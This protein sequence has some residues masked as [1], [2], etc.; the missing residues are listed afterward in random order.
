M[1]RLCGWVLLF[2]W[3]FFVTASGGA[4]TNSSPATNLISFHFV[5]SATNA[6][7]YGPAALSNVVA[8][9][10]PVLSDKDFV[11]FDVKKQEFTI[12]GAA[13]KRLADRIWEKGGREPYLLNGDVYELIPFP[14]LFVMKAEGQPI[15][16]GL[17]G[18]MVSSM[19]FSGPTIL[20]DEYAISPKQKANVDFRIWAGYPQPNGFNDSGKSDT[21][22]DSRI[23]AAVAKLFKRQ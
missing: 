23:S 11:S 7:P 10:T 3:S 18:T 22:R 5:L 4:A 12:T 2:S 20:A 9:A 19:S 1:K 21:R 17:F 8:E 6:P 15:Y 13:A 16:V 14:T